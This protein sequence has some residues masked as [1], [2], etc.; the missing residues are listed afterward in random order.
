MLIFRLIKALNVL[1]RYEIRHGVFRDN[2]YIAVLGWGTTWREAYDL[3]ARAGG[4]LVTIADKLENEFVFNLFSK[5]DRFVDVG[6]GGKDLNGPWIGLY[7]Q[8]GSK[9]PRGGWRWVT[10]EPLNILQLEQAP[11]K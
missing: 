9:E 1:G 2:L 4:H 3:S 11:A 5:D 6:E 8:Q 7:P 10:D